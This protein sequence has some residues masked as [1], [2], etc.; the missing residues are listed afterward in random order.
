MG[1]VLLS[2]QFSIY[3]FVAHC[4]SFVLFLLTI[5]LSLCHR[6]TVSLYPFY[7]VKPFCRMS[8]ILLAG[9]K[10]HYQTLSYPCWEMDTIGSILYILADDNIKI[11]GFKCNLLPGFEADGY[12]YISTC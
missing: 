12:I 8:Q 9:K 10:R 3:Y 6:F 1:F 2:P 4:L 5:V 7:I 11:I